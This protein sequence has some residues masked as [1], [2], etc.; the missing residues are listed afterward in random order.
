MNLISIEK[1]INGLNRHLPFFANT[2]H[3][4]QNTSK[5][6]IGITNIHKGL[7][8]LES[9][10]NTSICNSVDS[11]SYD[12]WH[13]KLGHLSDIGL[14]FVSRIFPFITCKSNLEPRDSCHNAKQKRL[15]FPSSHIYNVAPLDL[16]HANLWGPYSTISLLGQIYFLTL[17]DDFSRY[18]WVTFLKTKDQTKNSLINFVAYIE[19]QFNTTL[20]CLRSD[21]GMKFLTLAPFL[22]SKGIL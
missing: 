4:L 3:I 19:N 10:R 22:L 5:R 21:N 7:Y 9:Y 16:L 6:L 8:L 11:N 1:L 14:K 18:T 12:L 20:K 13:Y 17:V 15:S 2:C